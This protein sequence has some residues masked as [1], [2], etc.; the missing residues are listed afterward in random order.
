M[1]LMVFRQ[2]FQSDFMKPFEI[3]TSF[4]ENKVSINSWGNTNVID[5]IDRSIVWLLLFLPVETTLTSFFT[6]QP[7]KSAQNLMKL[8]QRPL[9]LRGRIQWSTHIKYKSVFAWNNFTSDVNL[10]RFLRTKLQR[11]VELEPAP[12]YR[13]DAALRHHTTGAAWSNTEY[14]YCHRS[15]L[16][17]I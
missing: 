3:L 16:L 2:Y 4:P 15:R 13:E 7:A 1:C 8:V 14:I 5:P 11:Q 12:H 10:R 6:Q 9:I 17:I